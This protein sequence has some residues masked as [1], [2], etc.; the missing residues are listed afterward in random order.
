MVARSR[1]KAVGAAGLI[2]TPHALTGGSI[3]VNVNLQDASLGFIGGRKFID[4]RPEHSGAFTKTIQNA[5][6]FYQQ[7]LETGFQISPNP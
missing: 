7:L 5:V 3:A 6:P 1:T 2:N 4:T